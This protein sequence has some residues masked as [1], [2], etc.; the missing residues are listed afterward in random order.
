MSEMMRRQA[1]EQLRR[2]AI[3]Q[4][5]QRRG[6]VGS[7]PMGARVQGAGIPGTG[8]AQLPMMMSRAAGQLSPAPGMRPQMQTGGMSTE[9]LMRPPAVGT[10][11]AGLPKAD[12]VLYGRTA[13]V[14]EERLREARNLL[15]EYKQAKHCTDERI[16]R[17]QE[18]WRQRNWQMIEEDR[19]TVGTQPKKSATAWLKTSIVGKHADHMEAYP[20]PLFLARNAEDEEEAKHLSEILPVVLKQIRFEETYSEVGWQKTI[21]GTGVYGVTWDG[22]AEGGMGQICIRKVNALNLYAE[23]GIE[24][25]QDSSN[26]FCVRME[27]DRKLEAAYP[28]LRG[29]LGRNDFQPAEYREIDQKDRRQKS[30]VIDWYYKKTV[31]GRQLLHYCQFVS[32]V[33][34]FASENDPQMAQTGF[35]AHGE[36]PFVVDAYMPDAETIYGQGVVDEAKDT[37]T[38]IDTMSQAL[39]T[40]AVANATPRYFSRSDG[41]V[42][43]E[44][45]LDWSK[46]IVHVN[47]NL[48]AD[49]LQKVDVPQVDGNTI[50]MYQA[51]VEELKTVTGN[52]DVVNGDVPAGVTS[53]VAIAALKEDAGR[54]SKDTNRASY[55][56]MERLYMMCVELI[57]QFY[58]MDRQFR[59]VGEDGMAS[60]MSYSNRNLMLR[61]QMGM[62]GYQSYRKPYFDVDVHVQR[63]NAYTRMAMNDLATQFYQ[64]GIFD[65]TRAPQALA[66]LRMMEFTGKEKIIQMVQQNFM[67]MMGQMGGNA[68]GLG[69]PQQA[70]QPGSQGGSTPQEQDETASGKPRNA[71]A[72]TPATDRMTQRIND[73]V[74]P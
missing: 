26:V 14:D 5:L 23:P 57:R 17:A 53:G 67:M 10:D 41:A 1:S 61:T 45:F 70:A 72:H 64:M 21:E 11:G 59:I 73:A 71:G 12:P 38:D 25:I 50:S 15:N 6:G 51:K 65:P 31:N 4:A 56:A 3:M 18:W 34:L 39:V 9:Q 16:I 20:E 42:N 43:E 68:A 40:S 33:V 22:Q 19:G 13:P 48:G 62:D 28:Q 30:L 69:Q 74:R 60:Y 55:R 49:S 8:A 27:D 32:D 7:Q 29:R 24:D 37:Q 66:M 47:G 35:Y 58:T 54:S 44:E 52:T 63:E 46:P 36:Y 2:Q